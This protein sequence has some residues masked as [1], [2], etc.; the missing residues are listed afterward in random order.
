MAN[1]KFTLSQRREIQKAYEGGLTEEEIVE[2]YFLEARDPYE[3][4]KA[5][6]LLS[7]WKTRYKWQT[8]AAIEK[9]MILQRAKS[10]SL[11]VREST[12][13]EARELPSAEEAIASKRIK[14]GDEGV[15]LAMEIMLKKLKK[16]A[17]NPGLVEDIGDVQGIATAGRAM[18]S[19]SGMG[20]TTEPGGVTILWGGNA[21][22][23]SPPCRV[24][25]V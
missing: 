7:V 19:L 25:D 4:K 11:G 5:L 14:M 23:D 6:T 20:K 16:A 18:H 17:A 9:A 1:S 8:K 3:I 10:E 2:T 13:R 22:K 24:I 15:N 21:Q 12:M